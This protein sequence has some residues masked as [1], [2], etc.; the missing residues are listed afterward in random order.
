MSRQ[1]PSAGAGQTALDPKHR[2]G[3]PSDPSEEG[4]SEHEEPAVAPSVYGSACA[5]AHPGRPRHAAS[6]NESYRCL[7]RPHPMSFPGATGDALR[8]W[9]ETM[10]VLTKLLLS[11]SKNFF[12]EKMAVF[13]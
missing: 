6:G 8:Q 7:Q 11:A 2:P 5:G 12:L 4:L 3:S 9:T 10:A 1:P 13:L